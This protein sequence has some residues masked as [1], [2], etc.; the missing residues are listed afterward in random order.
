MRALTELL[1]VLATATLA[2]V[3]GIVLLAGVLV[4][5]LCGLACG[6]LLLV[7][8]ASGAGFAFTGN[9]HYGVVAVGYLAYAAVPFAA[10]VALSYY[11]G[12]FT[13]AQESRRSLRRI[14]WVRLAQDEPFE[15]A[16]TSH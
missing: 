5:W 8:V 13:D 2:F 12:K 4:M 15:V 6:L 11:H 7:A 10:I 14:S 9:H 3:T 1:T 16:A